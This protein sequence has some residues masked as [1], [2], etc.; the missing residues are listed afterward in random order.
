M[1][2]ETNENI[3]PYLLWLGIRDPQRPP[4]H[5]QLLGI[6]VYE[7]NPDTISSAA[8]RRL[9]RVNSLGKEEYPEL[10]ARLTGEIQTAASC[11]LLEST[12]EQYESEF[13][14]SQPTDAAFP[15]L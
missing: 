1:S 6:D 2:E 4:N 5:Y 3:D 10:A 9:A 7:R 14:A 8:Q 12:R 15:G 11:L 13:Q